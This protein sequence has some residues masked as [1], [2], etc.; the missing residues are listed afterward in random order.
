MNSITFK[1]K[2]ITPMLMHG[3]DGKSAEL[4][5]ASIKGILRFWWRAI[6]GNL[7]L[8]DLHEQEGEIFGSTDKRS[9]FSIKIQRYEGIPKTFTIQF[10]NH[11]VF[12]IQ[13]FFELVVILGLFGQKG[14]GNQKTQGS[15]KITQINKEAYTQKV[16]LDYIDSLLQKVTDNFLKQKFEIT[17]TTKLE[18][19]PLVER[20]SISQTNELYV[21]FIHSEKFKT[22]KKDLKAYNG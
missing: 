4:R 21:N 10:L 5:P 15:I 1:C 13:S 3:A 7:P 17:Q 22:I 12:D 16:T 8:K 6:H 2:T 9:S 11:G 20:I 19:Y 14:K 18:I